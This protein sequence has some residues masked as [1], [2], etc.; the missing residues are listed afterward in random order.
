MQT[1][2]GF[3][4]VDG[5][6]RDDWWAI[7]FN[8]SQPYRLAHML[9]ASGLT[10]AFL[11]AGISA[12]QLLR[13]RGISRRRAACCAWRGSWRRC[14]HRCRSCG[15]R[16][17]RAQHARASAGQDRRGGSHLAH[18]AG[19]PAAALRVPNATEQ[20]NDY[21][22][23]IPKGASL[24][25]THDAEAEL[26]GLNE[27]AGKHPPVAAGLLRVPG[28][29]GVG[30]L[31]LALS[32]LGAWLPLARRRVPR[33]TLYASPAPPSSAGWGCWPAGS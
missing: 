19:R 21:A 6:P 5:V 14:S 13:N 25:L 30:V 8:P 10:V 2:Q 27:F 24:I 17:A 11:L 7:I 12:F 3:T 20:R 28:H 31:M 23:A 33:W 32:W 1:P 18:G 26:L 29:G 15:W 9:I 16:H 22:I 4:I